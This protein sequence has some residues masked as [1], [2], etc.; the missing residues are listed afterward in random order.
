MAAANPPISAAPALP[1]LGIR[2]LL[3]G[4][5]YQ[6]QV[7]TC[8]V[9]GTFMV[10]LDQTVVNIA[11]PKITTVFGV[12][13]HE[14]QLVVTSYMLALAVIMPATG[15][16][17]D[18]FGTKRL[19]LIT[20][21][22]FT[23]GSLLCG[24][25]WNNTSL[26]VFRVIQGL[27]GGMMT[28]L[29]MTMLFQ[30]VPPQRRNTMMGFFGLP[31]MLAPV[32]GPTLGGYLVEYIDWRVIFT[33]NV[34]VGILGL[35]L[36]FTLLR[37]TEHVPGLKFDLRGFVLSAIGF[38][39]I[40]LALSDAA[41][42]GWT[43]PSVL[44]RFGIG[45]VAL[46]AWVWVELT[47]KH[48]LLELR[49]FKI[50][51]FT[52]SSLVTF[53]LTIGMF[54]GMLILPLFLQNLR[55]LGAA[56]TGLILIFQVLPMTIAMPLVGRL[57]DKVGA[58][59]VILTGLPLLALTTWQFGRLDLTTS[60][61]TIRFWLA[62][63]GCAMGLVMM[64]SMTAGLNAVPMP[65]MS[66]ASSMS[67]VMRQVFGAFGTAIVVTMLQQRQTFHTAMLAQTVTPGN[68]P[69]QQLMSMAQQWG[70]AQG[71]T[72]AQAQA[73]G[74]MLAVRQVSIT[75]AVM[76]FDDVFRF[77]AVITLLAIIPALFMKT[78]KSPAGRGP[79]IVAD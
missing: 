63:R 40:L 2:G 61:A 41:T 75:A 9:V 25:A 24:L 49:L 44:G 60:D 57:V 47:D 10:M 66:R 15:Y 62:A 34:P 73:M 77:T 59:A 51:I 37:E 53:V 14:T 11:L 8:A 28:P 18:T 5:D 69:L 76:G 50:P 29:G 3:H 36:G 68:L 45:I 78:T 21:A 43:S 72:A 48:P 27:G 55:G 12:G 39:A 13:V 26:V 52:L 23:G 70:L 42:D 54:G 16:L 38:S 4:L 31:L 22:L 32:L 71:L 1:R 20:M 30:V 79:T 33:L 35:F 74:M 56:E 17:S 7:L 64:P 67:N 65:L 58:R 6:W 46:L 19:Y